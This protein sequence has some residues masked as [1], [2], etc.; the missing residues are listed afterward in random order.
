MYKPPVLFH[1]Y[2]LFWS[3]LRT[4]NMPPGKPSGIKTI[5]SSIGLPQDLA[6]Y[7]KQVAGHHRACSLRHS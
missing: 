6:P 3:K 7:I 4:K 1:G 5:T 2:P